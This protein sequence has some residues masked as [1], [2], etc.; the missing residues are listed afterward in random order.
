M[1]SISLSS[2]LSRPVAYAFGLFATKGIALIMLPVLA[3]HLSVQQIGQLE[4][5][6]TSGV[7][8]GMILGLALHESLY[9][10][11][12]HETCQHRQRTIAG[13]IYTLACMV[14]LISLCILI[15]TIHGVARHVTALPATEMTLLAIGVSTEG[16][17]GLQLA[18]LRMQ[19]KAKHFLLVTVCCCLL[20][21][22]LVVMSLSWMPSIT[23]ILAASVMTH[24]AQVIWL[25]RLCRLPLIQ[26]KAAQTLEFILYS[27]PI[28]LSGMVAFLMNGAERW[29]IATTDTIES[30]AFYAIAAKFALALCIL[31]QPFGMWWMPKRFSV[32][33]REG[34]KQAA[35][36]T[37]FGL[38]WIAMLAAGIAY[39]AP[40]F[41]TLA[42]P[43]SYAPAVQMVLLCLAA[44][45]FK[46]L[47]ELF[48]LGL[49]IA[50]QTGLL[51]RFNLMAVMVSALLIATMVSW[52]IVGIIA[53]LIGGQLTKLILVYR[54]SQRAC[55]LPYT[56]RRSTVI[57]LIAFI[58]L[59]LASH[60][61]P[62]PL[63][64]LMSVL[65]PLSVFA[66][67]LLLG[68]VSAQSVLHPTV[69]SQASRL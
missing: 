7:F 15:L 32:Y 55:F 17:I 4:L 12:G 22:T 63:Q 52:G 28:A 8:I 24:L 68:I 66:V 19:D 36:I 65:A 43:A 39:F 44:A 13:T 30:L 10:F 14:A 18:W 62:W 34:A 5:Y 2:A 67:A 59:L 35:R 60:V 53:G 54:A 29:V 57:L 46:E 25:Q 23:S 20:Q 40:M 27:I 51:L 31:V 16:V 6:T 3:N 61:H 38:V 1:P 47:S 42:L 58:H 11:A 9:R 45:L 69:S 33:L 48:N 41:I 49:L 64:L 50:K 56:L 26:P 37:Q 21:V